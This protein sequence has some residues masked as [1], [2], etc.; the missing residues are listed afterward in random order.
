MSSPSGAPSP[1]HL[2]TPDL[3]VLSLLAEQPRHGYDIV[4]E[5]SRRAVEDWAG[6]SRPQ[7]YYSLKKLAATGMIAPAEGMNAGGGAERQVYAITGAGTAALMGGLACEE[8][9]TGRVL[10]PFL[11]WLALSPHAPVGT[12]AAMIAR[13]AAFLESEIA[14]EAGHLE[15]IR[16]HGG[17]SGRVAELMVTHKVAQWKAER[18]WLDTVR[19]VLVGAHGE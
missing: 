12:I 19:E 11:T 8:W 10:P 6:V 5:L 18:Q 14:K 15:T 16:A 3:V 9:A 17:A 2:T 13:R 1:I 4:A 7:V